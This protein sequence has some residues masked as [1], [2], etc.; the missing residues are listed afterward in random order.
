MKGKE[1]NINSYL[2]R[3]REVARERDPKVRVI[4][5]F[6]RGNFNLDV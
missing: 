5:S 3:I 1:K 4:G 6:V 2:N